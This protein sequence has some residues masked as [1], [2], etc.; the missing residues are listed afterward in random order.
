MD[1]F[2]YYVNQMKKNIILIIKKIN[3]NF[4]CNDNENIKIIK[5]ILKVDNIDN[6]INNINNINNKI[7]DL[8]YFLESFLLIIHNNKI[9]IV[10][11]ILLIFIYLYLDSNNFFEN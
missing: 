9:S 5:D 1:S 10:L 11:C 8:N 4:N 7:Y 6:N 2:Q 3:K